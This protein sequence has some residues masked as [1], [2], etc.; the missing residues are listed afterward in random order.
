MSL[1]PGALAKD[2]VSMAR[3]LRRLKRRLLLDAY[4]V[5]ATP[6]NKND[7]GQ[8][9][10]L[11]KNDN[12]GANLIIASPMTLQQIALPSLDSSD[13]ILSPGAND[14]EEERDMAVGR[15]L[16]K[17]KR[18]LLL[19]RVADINDASSSSSSSSK[20][21][22]TYDACNKA[23]QQTSA[24]SNSNDATST[25]EATILPK[26]VANRI[27]TIVGT[28]EVATASDPVTP[29]RLLR[30]MKRRLLLNSLDLTSEDKVIT[31]QEENPDGIPSHLWLNSWS[32][33]VE[34]ERD[35][36]SPQKFSL[37]ARSSNNASSEIQFKFSQLSLSSEDD[38]DASA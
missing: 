23:K 11:G 32:E 20:T 31:K 29:A 21:P 26:Q 30:R 12:A 6:M 28:T 1:S 7:E 25:E 10:D 27:G 18:R 14:G 33:K 16:R 19:E 36:A 17:L 35:G 38:V 3:K 4:S 5:P 22:T 9:K 37:H 24:R 13:F 34:E 8:T 2:D 15:K